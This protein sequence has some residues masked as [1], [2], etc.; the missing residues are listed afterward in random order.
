[1]MVE[2]AEQI[3]IFLD[4]F[5]F[6]YKQDFLNLAKTISPNVSV[7][8]N[9]LEGSDLVLEKHYK[10]RTTHHIEHNSNKQ[11]RQ[12]SDTVE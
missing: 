5:R 3:L 6:R 11:W 12:H 10:S 2:K 9:K 8:R 4:P 7:S 1:M